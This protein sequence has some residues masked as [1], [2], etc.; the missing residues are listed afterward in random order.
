MPRQGV[1][2]KMDIQRFF[3][4]V[5]HSGVQLLFPTRCLMCGRSGQGGADLCEYC[6]QQLPF[7]QTACSHCALPLPPGTSD[8][9]V[10]G[11]CQKKPPY[12][13]EAFSL[14]S[15]EQP[16]IWLI[17]QL[18]FN[19]KLVHAR[20]LGQLLAASACIEHI[21]AGEEVC[22]LPVPLYKKRLRQRGFNQSIELARALSKKTG[23]PMDLQRVVRIRDTSAQTGLD[24][25][26]RRKNIRG[27]F[28]VVEPLPQ[29]HVVIV[30]DVVTTGSTANE[31]SRVLKKSGVKK[32]TVLSLA[33]APLN[34]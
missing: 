16:V 28:A 19:E 26:A 7:N 3:Y 5:V 22:I 24:A 30:D 4:S 32:I 23:W 34:R 21:G 1:F 25:K 14:F 31:L 13:N 12:Y 29:K 17:Q 18:K 33:R 8:N 11:R 20:L 15:Y 6:H 2:E 27:A 10:C 9:A